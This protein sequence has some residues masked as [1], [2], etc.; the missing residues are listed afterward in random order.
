MVPPPPQSIGG[1]IS[2]VAFE[3]NIRNVF[4]RIPKKY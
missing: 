2:S 4:N 3:K 1:N